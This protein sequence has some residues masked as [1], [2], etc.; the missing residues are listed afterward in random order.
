MGARHK[1]NVAAVHGVFLVAGLI[2]LVIQSWPVFLG[3][4]AVM[5]ATA[6]YDGSIRLASR[7]RK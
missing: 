1:L 2:A 3:S 4:V 6:V 7:R 5:L